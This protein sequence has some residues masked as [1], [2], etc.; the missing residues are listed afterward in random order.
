MPEPFNLSLGGI[1][2]S[3]IPDRADG[4]YE[5]VK[6]AVEFR[7]P[8]ESE[9]TLQVGCGWF[10]ELTIPKIC[11]ETDLGWQ[12]LQADGKYIIRVRSAEQ[13]PYQLGIFPGDFRS[14]EIFIAPS[15]DAPGHYI[16]PL[17][18][19]MGELFM[20]NL[21]GTGLGMLFHACGVIYQGKGY[22]FTGHG[23]AG[24]TTTARLW[25]G[26]AG[27]KVVN[28]DKVIIRQEA[29]EFRLYGTPWHGEGGMVLPDSAPLHRIFILKQAEQNTVISLHPVQAAGMLLARSF[30]PLW[31]A[32][33]IEFSLKFLDELCQAVPCQ[34]FG[35]LP[36]LSAVQFAQGLSE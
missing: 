36:D 28:D 12:M 7:S 29:G 13:D 24:K 22:L 23:G 9:I 11:F 20:M 33:K 32:D 10:P 3:L 26:I 6:R 17:S 14:G 34:E 5:L 30:V 25:E 19:P 4:E 18:Y 15:Q 31:D 21:L 27:A 2:I 16:F 1:P 8:T 35:F